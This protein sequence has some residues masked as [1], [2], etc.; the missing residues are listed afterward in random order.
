MYPIYNVFLYG[1][2]ASY[3]SDS[4]RGMAFGIFDAIGT[5]GY[6]TGILLLGVVAD[7]W[8]SGTFAGIFSMFLMSL[9]FAIITFLIAL[10][11]Y[12][13]KLRKEPKSE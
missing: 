12:L 4:R 13:L 11:F 5:L 1:L 2:T 3:S 8:T 10:G 7:S 9:I 6:V